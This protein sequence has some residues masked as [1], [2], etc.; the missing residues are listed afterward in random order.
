MA[1]K[2]N[3]D[4]KN[5]VKKIKPFELYGV[6][7]DLSPE[8][9]RIVKNLTCQEHKFMYCAACKTYE[10]VQFDPLENIDKFLKFIKMEQLKIHP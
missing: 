6:Q 10:Q 5:F 3:L 2:I 8:L 9:R 4:L 1:Q 7:R